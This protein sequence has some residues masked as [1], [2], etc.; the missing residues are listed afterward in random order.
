MHPNLLRTLHRIFEGR[1]SSLCGLQLQ[2]DDPDAHKFATL[3]IASCIHL[4]NFAIGHEKKE[5][6]EADV[7]YI[8]GRWYLDREREEEDR[9]REEQRVQLR[10]EEADYDVVENVELL[11]GKIKWEELKKALFNYLENNWEGSCNIHHGCC[12]T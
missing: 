5:N 10:E 4:H 2:I 12:L 3:W 7:F 1:W 6:P 8:E 9:W 11:E